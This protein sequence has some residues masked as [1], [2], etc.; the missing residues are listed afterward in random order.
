M[1]QKVGVIHFKNLKS[2]RTVKRILK[3]DLSFP[4]KKNVNYKELNK[5]KI[6]KIVT[7][8]FNNVFYQAKECKSLG[9]E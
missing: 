8:I 5:N 2:P 4:K 1:P 7:D 6:F 3:Q 9:T